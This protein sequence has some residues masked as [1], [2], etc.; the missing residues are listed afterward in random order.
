M[1]DRIVFVNGQ[2]FPLMDVLE[3]VHSGEINEE[4]VMEENDDGVEEDDY[5]EDSDA[6]IN[7][8]PMDLASLQGVRNG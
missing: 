5:S 8:T 4:D 3:M 1:T 6:S 7:M 2:R